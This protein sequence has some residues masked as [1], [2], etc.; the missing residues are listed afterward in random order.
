MAIYIW[1]PGN[2]IVSALGGG[3]IH[4]PNGLAWVALGIIVDFC[5]YS[6]FATLSIPPFDGFSPLDIVRRG[7]ARQTPSSRSCIAEGERSSALKSNNGQ[8]STGSQGR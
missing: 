8:E 7:S 2:E 5:F 3:S 1:L 6:L 4:D